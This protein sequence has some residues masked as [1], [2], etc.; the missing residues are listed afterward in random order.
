MPRFYAALDRD[1]TI[2][3]QKHYL[4]EPD[5]VELLSNAVTGLRHMRSLGLG[6]VVVTNQSPIGRGFFDEDQLQKVHNRLDQLLAEHALSIDKYYYCPNVPSDNAPCRK[7]NTGMLEQAAKDFNFAYA[8]CFVVGD[9]GTDIEMGQNVGATTFL[10]TTGYGSEHLAENRCSP[11]Y[12]VGDLYE[13]ALIIEQYL[14]DT[15][16]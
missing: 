8:D 6:L 16:K 1:G 14:K 4:S 7:P 12:V 10:V 5:E 9:K 11:D 2:I 13:M 15:K 3:V